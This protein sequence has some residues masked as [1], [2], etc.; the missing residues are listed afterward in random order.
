MNINDIIRTLPPMEVGEQTNVYHCKEGR[1]NDRLYIKRTDAGFLYNCFHCGLAGGVRA[2][3]VES[4]APRVAVKRTRYGSSG[5]SSKSLPGDCTATWSE[6]HPRARGW[7]GQYLTSTEVHD[8]GILYSPLLR[9]VILPVHDASGLAGYQTRKIFDDDD[10][11]KYATYTGRPQDFHLYL[12][13]K[14]SSGSSVV[15]VEDMVSAV[16]CSYHCASAALFGV[17][18]KDALFAKLARPASMHSKFLIFLDN[19]STLVRG[20]ARK[21]R[22]R[23]TPF[24]ECAIIDSR[25]GDPKSL[26]HTELERLLT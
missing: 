11:P 18:L 6:F 19:D 17:S 3:S 10:R 21:I 16:K 24:G 2:S 9:R 15:L 23:L 26:T 25:D 14:S 7:L 22:Q 8:H 13:S 5:P 20:A 12:P 4:D 1:G